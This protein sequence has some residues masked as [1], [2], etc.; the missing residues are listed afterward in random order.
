VRQRYF[1]KSQAAREIT[2]MFVSQHSRMLENSRNI[3]PEMKPFANITIVN[4]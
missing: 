3:L 1:T 4:T 2:K